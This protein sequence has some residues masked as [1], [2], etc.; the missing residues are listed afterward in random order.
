MYDGADDA[1]Q[2]VLFAVGNAARGV[3]VMKLKDKP[4]YYILTAP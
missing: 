4:L 2:R 3:L 1:F